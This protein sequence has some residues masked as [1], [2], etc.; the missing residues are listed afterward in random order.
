ME[1]T[2]TK[3]PV[4]GQPRSQRGSD[5]TAAEVARKEEGVAVSDDTIRLSEATNLADTAYRF[6]TL[7]KWQILTVVAL[8]QTSMSK[9]FSIPSQLQMM[10]SKMSSR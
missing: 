1:N 2:E 9:L 10:N 7:R 4:V 3:D 6:S 8:C 5:S